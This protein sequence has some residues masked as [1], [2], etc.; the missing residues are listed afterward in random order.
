VTAGAAQRLRLSA[1]RSRITADGA[2]LAV[3]AAQVLD[4]AGNPVPTAGQRL[5]FALSGPAR[6]L[7][8]GNGDPTDHDPDNAPDRRAFNGL[9]QA[10]VQSDGAAGAI[11]LT[12]SGEG[13]TPARVAL[14]AHVQS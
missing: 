1:S 9:A 7:G 11:T 14:F 3:I 8:T 5:H 10:L 13:L 4:H 6:L 12:V 2:D